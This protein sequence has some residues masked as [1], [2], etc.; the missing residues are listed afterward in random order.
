MERINADRRGF[1]IRVYPL[2][3]SS[4]AFYYFFELYRRFLIPSYRE[5]PAARFDEAMLFLR[6][7]YISLVGD[8]MGKSTAVT[9]KQIKPSSSR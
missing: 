7:W 6:E 3:P 1:F 2:N 4:S 9:H 8:E 5:L